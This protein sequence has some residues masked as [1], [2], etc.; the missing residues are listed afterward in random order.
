MKKV[1]GSRMQ[2]C[3]Q[4]DNIVMSPC[5][6]RLTCML[7]HKCSQI[8]LL[9]TSAQPPPHHE[10]PVASLAVQSRTLPASPTSVASVYRCTCR[11]TRRMVEL[12]CPR[13]KTP[14]RPRANSANTLS[15][16]RGSQQT[17]PFSII[18]S[19]IHHEATR[20]PTTHD[21]RVTRVT[22]SST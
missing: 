1:A 5:T 10:T 22:Q 3:L 13:V 9:A 2:R 20:S 14:S 7:T 16:G 18:I 11:F 19:H 8:T 21:H 4:T 12:W 17:S 15:D 6:K